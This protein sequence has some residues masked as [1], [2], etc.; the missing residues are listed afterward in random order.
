ME[1]L[2]LELFKRL[3]NEKKI[4]ELRTIFNEYNSV[5]IAETIN[6]LS[7]DELLFLFKVIP[8]YNSA[9]VFTYLS[10]EAKEKLISLFSSQDIQTVLEKI[11]TDDIVDFIEDLPTN[12]VRKVLKS[13]DKE[14][15]NDVNKILNYPEDSVASIMN[16]GY[17]ELEKDDTCKQALKK[18]KMQGEK[19]E[20]ISY[21][22]IVDSK[23]TLNG[24]I[25]LKSI[26]LADDNEL[27]GNLM[28][29]DLIS[30]MFEDDKEAAS[31]IFKKYD[32]S[33][34]PVVNKENKL[35]GIITAD[36][37]LDVITQEATEDIQIMSGS[38]PLE[39]AYLETSIF[40][41]FKKRFGWLLILMISAVFTSM[42]ISSSESVL[43][44]IPA[45]AIFMPMLTDTAGNAG[46]QATGIVTRGISINTIETKDWFKV[47]WKEVR[48]AFLVGISM[49]LCAYGWLWIEKWLGIIEV[50][51][52]S[53]FL[54]VSLSMF[55]SILIA[56]TIGACLPI[57][58]KICKLDPA[59]MAGPIVTTL[60]DA[61]TVALYYGL[62]SLLL[63]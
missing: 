40:S 17:I 2:N 51:D 10:Q 61:L 62:A 33:V 58:A 28:E 36:D 59:V 1:E 29:K 4:A 41:L 8:A 9:E 43:I 57:L 53:L 19:A 23:R 5:D 22:Y 44:T 60:V 31:L 55:I 54:V 3:I 35:L 21:A 26:I 46:N 30:V 13:I 11:Y 48:V 50:A 12:L 27:I 63:I 18:V 45:L 37:I 7:E 42:I 16:I 52:T 56:K 15:R 38:S 34:L 14:T 25:S 32:M 6:D 24:Y 39:G 20:S 49:S 47:V